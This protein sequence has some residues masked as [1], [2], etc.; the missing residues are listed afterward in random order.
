MLESSHTVLLLLRESD[1]RE[2]GRNS[3]FIDS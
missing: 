3:A 1:S 2:R